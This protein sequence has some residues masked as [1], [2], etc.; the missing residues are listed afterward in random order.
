M[1]TEN[2]KFQMESNNIGMG[3]S[4]VA[5]VVKYDD[6][7]DDGSD[8]NGNLTMDEQVPAGSFII[9]C[10]VTVKTGF[11]GDTTA[12]LSVGVVNDGNDVSGNTTISILAAARNLVKS[13]FIGADAGLRAVSSDQSIYLMVAGGSDFSDITAGEMLVEVFYFSTN[14]ELTNGAPTEIALNG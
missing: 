11:T 4:K 7:T 8:T 9:G 5:Q 12:V 13:C 3:I 14:V 1:S 6:F 10:K 2:V